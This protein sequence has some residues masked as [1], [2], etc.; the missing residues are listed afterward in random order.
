M[1][2]ELVELDTSWWGDESLCNYKTC[3]I[4]DK[5]PQI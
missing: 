2:A 3:E 5:I 4:S 1:L